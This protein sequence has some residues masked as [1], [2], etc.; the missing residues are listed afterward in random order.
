MK[1]F[2]K[3][4]SY[5]AILFG[6]TSFV[7]GQE[8]YASNIKLDISTSQKMLITYDLLSPEINS[9]YNVSLTMTYRG[10]PLEFNNVFGDF[11]RLITAGREKAIVWYYN[12]DFEGNIADVKVDIMASMIPAPV[13]GFDYEII[14]DKLPF[15]V[16]FQNKS[17]NSDSYI[18]NFDDSGSGPSNTTNLENPE[19]TYLR[20]RVFVVSLTAISEESG[21]R[22]S[23]KVQVNLNLGDLPVSSFKYNLTSKA[24]PSTV[25]F[26]NSATH[27]DEY[28]WSFDDPDSGSN[29]YSAKKNPVHIFSLPGSYQVILTVTNTES[30]E[31]HSHSENIV[32]IDSH[33]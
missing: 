28:H 24:A 17:K 14:G 4:L 6:L 3:A 25:W 5:F 8:N 9:L 16:V 21:L 12:N 19:H 32:V 31:S 27:A 23:V 1:F 30:M 29:N 15:T 10:S 13:A 22:D 7:V 26:K 18:W 33:N 20:A 11:G 2:C